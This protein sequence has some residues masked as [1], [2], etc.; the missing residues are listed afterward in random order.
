[1]QQNAVQKLH[2]TIGEAN[3]ML[4][5]SNP[6]AANKPQEGNPDDTFIDLYTAVVSQPS[7]G[8]SL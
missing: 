6:D 5:E 7:I 3:K 1:M 4:A 2:I 8:K